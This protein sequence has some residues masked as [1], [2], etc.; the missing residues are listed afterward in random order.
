MEPLNA[1]D[2][3]RIGE[4]W[5]AG[6]LGEGGQGVVYEAYDAGGTRVALKLLHADGRAR[7]RFAKEAAAAARVASFCTARVLAV[8]P[9][10]R[11]PYLVSEYVPGP[12][13][14]RAGR[15]FAGDELHR[16]ATAIATALAAIH[17]A[18]VIHRDLK[19]DNVLLGPDG[20]RVIDFGIARTAEMSLTGTGEVSGTPSYMPP[21]V[22]TGQRAGMPGDVFAWGAVVV[23][24]ATGEDPFRA[25]N[26]GGVMHRVLSSR[27][28]L[29]MLPERLR[30]LVAAALEKDPSA[31]PAAR[32]LL[33]ALVGPGGEPAVNGVHAVGAN[34]PALGTIAEDAYASLGP[35]ERELAA[36]VFLRLVTVG[37]DGQETGRGASRAELLD[38]RS[39]EE[40]AAVARVLR[41]FAYVVATGEETVELS[42][43]ALLR[44][45][46]R[47]RRWVD[48]D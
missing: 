38:G 29:S 19:P 11:R 16:L 5:L 46:P 35:Q 42:L 44:A 21:E 26:L 1:E 25:D 40:A 37:E 22:F 41:A 34:D 43:P 14:R 2:P 45:W 47:L 31:R 36:E 10:G 3:Q 7:D 48:D 12:S 32:D 30:P 8:E 18:G 33:L 23:F 4:Y 17:E 28:D 27:P 15:T 6:R 20:P 9:D 13:L 24:A 39:A